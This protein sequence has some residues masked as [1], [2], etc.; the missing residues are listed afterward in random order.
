M[1]TPMMG[2]T[3]SLKILLV[4]D[5]QENL[6]LL[7]DVLSESGYTCVQAQNG[8]DALG[9]LQKETVHLIVADAMMPKMDGFQLCKEVRAMA[10]PAK[11]PFIIYTG[12]YVDAAD[13]EF[14]R[15]I[16]VD[17]YVV[18]Y[19]GLGTLVEAVNELAKQRYGR[20]PEQPAEGQGQIDDQVFLEQHH[21]IIIKKLEEKIR[22]EL[23][24]WRLKRIFPGH[25]DYCPL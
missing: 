7:E 16:G 21:A 15:S 3:T 11:I 4:D 17:R 5:V 24:I 13:Q 14:A 22:N 9:L 12:N 8:V 23:A 19:A 18:K 2:A 20:H 25:C 6:E 10:G 1:D